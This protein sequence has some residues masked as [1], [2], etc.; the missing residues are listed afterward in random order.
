MSMQALERAFAMAEQAAARLERVPAAPACARPPR[1]TGKGV[2]SRSSRHLSI[3]LEHLESRGFISPHKPV[4]RL[5][6]EMRLIR[7]QV[8][9]AAFPADGGPAGGPD[10]LNGLA[11]TLDVTSSV[12]GEGK[13][14]IAVNLAISLA[15]EC[16][17]HVLLVDG[18]VLRPSVFAMMGLEPA[19]GLIDVLQDPALDLGAA[20][21]ATSIPKLSL[22]SAGRQSAFSAE[23]LG[24][25]RMRGLMREM[26]GRYPDRM[27]IL[28][29]PPLLAAS[30]SAVLAHEAD[31]VLM[32]VEAG[33]TS[34]ATLAS[35]LLMVEDCPNV[36]LLLN[37]ASPA[38]SDWDFG[39]IYRA[40]R[41]RR[42][43]DR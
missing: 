38:V 3:D 6:E 35:A 17:T 23:L 39:R 9:N 1:R 28:D 13:T 12:D 36:A 16:D 8:L 14:F 33:R 43:K 15:I 20:I 40:Y 41:R 11:N 34:E 31:Q 18:D 30:D 26:A 4:S 42:P 19:V 10:G 27:I 5:S 7:R 2:A 29:S 25:R 22:L 32:V 24:S 21:A 37:K